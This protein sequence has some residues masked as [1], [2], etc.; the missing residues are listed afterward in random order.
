MEKIKLGVFGLGRGRSLFTSMLAAGA[1]IVAVCEKDERRIEEAKKIAGE[2]LAVYHDFDEFIEHPMDAVMLCNYFNEHAEYAV[3]CLERGIHV[4]S[5]TTSNGTMAEGVRLVRAAE[6]SRAFYMLAE[7]Y[8]F[9]VF[10][11]EMRRVYREGSLGHVLFA[12]GE[13]NHPLNPDN[14]AEIVKLRPSPTHWRSSLPSTYYIT[15]SLAPLMYITGQRPVKVAAMPVMAHEDAFICPLYSRDLAAIITTLNDDG[16]V[17]RVT[18]CAAFGAHG[19]SYRICAERGQIENLRGTGGKIMLRYDPWNVPEGKEEKNFYMPEFPEEDR[20]L[21]GKA[22]HGGGDFY[23]FREFLNCIREN[24]RPEFD[25]YFATTMAS[26]AI[27]A[28]RSIL[29]NG[30][31]YD[32]PDFH[33][34]EDRALWEKD[35]LN[36]FY[37]KNGEAPTISPCSDPDYRP[38]AGKLDYY[39]TAWEKNKR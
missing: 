4:L 32:I 31:R 13:Y 35:N 8:P 27:L 25:E 39:K 12:E 24:K 37:G 5:E 33:R 16:S 23:I 30:K 21:I 15:H 9:M 17:F 20:E 11:Q 28:H 26:V 29:E 10:N 18:G 14:V 19:N 6:K 3:R 7:N 1:Q 22:G 34:E 36:P 38:S 2:G